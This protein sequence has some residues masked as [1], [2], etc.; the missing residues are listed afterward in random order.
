MFVLLLIILWLV[1]WVTLLEKEVK[2]SKRQYIKKFNALVK[3]IKNIEKNQNVTFDYINDIYKD[4]E[5]FGIN[6]EN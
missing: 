1:I 5:R 2:K 4:L 6:E 3:R